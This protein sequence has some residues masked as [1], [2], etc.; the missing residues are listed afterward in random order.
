M[1]AVIALS[2][3]MSSGLAHADTL[4]IGGCVGGGG[5]A[6]CVLRKGEATDPYVRAVPQPTNDADKDRATAREHKWIDRCQPVI[7]QDR[8]GVPR[9]HYSAW[10]CE[11]GVIE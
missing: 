9:Y 3:I 5:A 4:W 2:Y 6:N 8:Y 10:G 1:G 7:K 11:F